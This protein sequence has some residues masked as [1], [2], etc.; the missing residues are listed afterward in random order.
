MEFVMSFLKNQFSD[1][2]KQEIRKT[3]LL[4]MR[5][6]EQIENVMKLLESFNFCLKDEI[7]ISY[8]KDLN[9]VNKQIE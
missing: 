3:K 1:L 6:D 2:L 9:D 8:S 5:K 7:S 4:F